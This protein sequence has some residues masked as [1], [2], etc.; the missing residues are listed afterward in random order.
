VE[1]V[2]FAGGAGRGQTE[3]M[4]RGACAPPGATWHPQRVFL[5]HTAELREHPR[6]LSF[7][8]AAESA[9]ARA[10]FAVADQAYLAAMARSP[11]DACRQA[12]R[13]ADVYL[14]IIGFRYGT[15]AGQQ[16]GPSYTELEFDTATALGMP[17]LI[18]LLD[19]RGVIPLP[20]EQIVDAAHGARQAEFR[21]RL[22]DES[23]LM[24]AYVTTPPELET[25]VY[26]A[27]VEIARPHRSALPARPRGGR[28][29]RRPAAVTVSGG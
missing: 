5:S 7:A 2:S 28:P 29:A 6:P 20:A 1:V 12:I 15:L 24:I 25:A 14:G 9:V 21:R 3:F 23:D 18:F 22:R 27:L 8:A 10:R 13:D 17:R 19:E 16:T 11:A 4:A 26:Q